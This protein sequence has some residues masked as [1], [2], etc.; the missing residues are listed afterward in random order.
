MNNRVVSVRAAPNR[1]GALTFIASFDGS[2]GK[3]TPFPE[4]LKLY[5]KDSREDRQH[6]LPQAHFSRNGSEK[7][8]YY[9]YSYERTHPGALFTISLKILDKDR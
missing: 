3:K 4:P 8:T 7:M 1:G 2:H 5:M 6:S 9:V